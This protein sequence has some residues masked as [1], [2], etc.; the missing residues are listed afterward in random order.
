MVMAGSGSWNFSCIQALPSLKLDLK[1]RSSLVIQK[2]QC[3][4]RAVIENR[5]ENCV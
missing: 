3:L 5:A 2:V 4:G 1:A